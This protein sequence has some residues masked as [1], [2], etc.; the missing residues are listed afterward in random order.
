MMTSHLDGQMLSF[1]PLFD[2][3]TGVV[4]QPLVSFLFS[5]SFNLIVMLNHIFPAFNK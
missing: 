4:S 1:K 3:S 5:A 2:S